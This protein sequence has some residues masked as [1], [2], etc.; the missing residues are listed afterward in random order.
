MCVSV[1][2]GFCGVSMGGGF[3]L[4]VACGYVFVFV[5]LFIGVLALGIC[6]GYLTVRLLASNVISGVVV[7]R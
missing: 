6:S 4:L 7:F 2:D 5:Y 3:G 1:Y